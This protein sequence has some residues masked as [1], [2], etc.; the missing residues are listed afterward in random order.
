MFQTSFYVVAN[1]CLFQWPQKYCR[2]WSFDSVARHNSLPLAPC[3]AMG[4][5]RYMYYSYL[6][7]IKVGN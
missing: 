3:V 1:L 5:G 6:F 2:Q 4:V 7:R